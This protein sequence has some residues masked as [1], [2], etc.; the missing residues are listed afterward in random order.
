MADLAGIKGKV[1]EIFKK[2][3]LRMVALF[4]LPVLL[5]ILW[6]TGVFTPKIK[7]GNTISKGNIVTGVGLYKISNNDGTA[8]IAVTGTVAPVKTA[9]ISSKIMASVEALSFHEGSTVTAGENICGLDGRDLAAQAE[10]ATA[11]VDAAEAGQLVQSKAIQQSEAGV[12]KANTVLHDAEVQYN[13]YKVLKS[14]A[15]V[16]QSDYDSVESQYHQAQAGQLA[17]QASLESALAQLKVTGAQT[18]QS[19][20]TLHYAQTMQGYSL[21]KAPFD[22]V[23]VKKMVN[24]GD[25]VT[26][27]QPIYQLEQPPYRLEVPVPENLYNQIKIG[28][29]VSVQIPAI[30]QTAQATVEEIV[31]AVEPKSLTYI[32]KVLLPNDFPVKSGMYGEAGFSLGSQQQIFIPDTAL[33]QWGDFTGAYIVRDNIARLVF[34]STG[35]QTG[36]KVAV[37]SGL[38]AGDIVISA[39]VSNVRDGDRVEG[40]IVHE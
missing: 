3:W 18:A 31:P 15:V 32:V 20:A 14:Q 4:L 2:G 5:L 40:S 10:Q 33:T 37:L 27:G 39:G 11:G 7:S 34:V 28:D 9:I 29:K 30:K 25:M 21:I 8:Q 12:E 23:I 1:T 19:R 17:A 6:T 24:I 38:E 36:G 16:S 13:R 22:G 26:P 35:A